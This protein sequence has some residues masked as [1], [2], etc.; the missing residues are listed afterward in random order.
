MIPEAQTSI[1]K[2][3]YLLPIITSGAVYEGDPHDVDKRSPSFV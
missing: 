1:E 2:P 3:S